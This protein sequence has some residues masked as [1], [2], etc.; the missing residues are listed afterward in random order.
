[1]RTSKFFNHLVATVAVAMAASCAKTM[2]TDEVADSG[3]ASG[4]S[5]VVRTAAN[6]DGETE[7]SDYVNYPVSVYVMD[8]DGQ[9]IALQQ[10]ASAGDQLKMELAEG[11]YGVYA[12]AGAESY[13]LPTAGEASKESLL[14]PKS[15]KGHGDLM[16]AASSVAMAKGEE[17]RLT[18]RL[19]RRVMQIQG[20]ALSNIPNDV[21]DVRLSIS[22]LRKG[23]TLSGEYP[24]GTGS[25]TFALVRQAD[26]TTWKSSASEY[27]LEAAGDVT[28]KVSLTRDGGAVAYSYASDNQ[29]AANHKVSITGRFVDDEHITLSGTVMGEDWAED[30]VLDFDFDSTNVT[31]EGDGGGSSEET[32]HGDAPEAGTIYNGCYV[33]RTESGGNAT[34]VTLMTPTEANKIKVSSSSDEETKQQSIKDNTATAL[35]GIA[36][37]GVLGWRLPTQEE[38]EYIDGNATDINAKTAALGESGIDSIALRKSGYDCGYFF[39]ATDGSVYVYVLGGDGIDTSPSSGRATYKVRG[40]ATIKFSD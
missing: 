37:D 3:A 19:Q 18:L 38:M 16:T 11:T 14:N 26:G 20:I 24:E 2:E 25:H 5:L 23:I 34:T 22:P 17:N 29:L 35:D 12:V 36:V 27:L 13:D 8:S 31:T 7:E 28:L 10:I 1:M 32:L 21:S 33:L 6:V 39:T 15:G 30:I 9:C 4:G 40:F